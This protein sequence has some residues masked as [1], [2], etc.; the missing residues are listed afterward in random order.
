MSVAVAPE[1]SLTVDERAV[2]DS[3]V[4]RARAAMQAIAD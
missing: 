3:L 1:R 2:A 4:A